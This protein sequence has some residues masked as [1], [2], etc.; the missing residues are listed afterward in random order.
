[1]YF[2][3]FQF[4]KLAIFSSILLFTEAELVYRDL[5]NITSTLGELKSLQSNLANKITEINTNFTST[6]T[7]TGITNCPKLPSV[8]NDFTVVSMN[9]ILHQ[10][11]SLNGVKIFLN[12]L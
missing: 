3:F 12:D 7:S 9:K 2:I 6:C 1:M 8:A 4:E 5:Q 11:K 10:L